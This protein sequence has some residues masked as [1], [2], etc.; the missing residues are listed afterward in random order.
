V[1]KATVAVARADLLGGL[2]R[3]VS[4]PDVRDVFDSQVWFGGAAEHPLRIPQGVPCSHT[5]ISR[6][7]VSSNC[8]GRRTKEPE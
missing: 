6:A 8:L 2:A 7:T 3:F 4:T 5:M 1:V